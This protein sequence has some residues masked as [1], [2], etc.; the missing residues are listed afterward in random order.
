M[1]SFRPKML[2]SFLSLLH[3]LIQREQKH[4]RGPSLDPTKDVFIVYS[5]KQE[6]RPEESNLRN[7]FE[8][9]GVAESKS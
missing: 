4:G 5:N 7:R 2:R 1:T 9:T 3:A 6:K 8:D